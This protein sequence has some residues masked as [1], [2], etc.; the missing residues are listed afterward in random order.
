M[1]G[2]IMAPTIGKVCIITEGSILLKTVFIAP[3]CTYFALNLVAAPMISC[4]CNFS[5]TADVSLTMVEG[6]LCCS[7][8]IF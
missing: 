2:S 3:H 4:A 5:S 6:D 7:C 1:S 8:V